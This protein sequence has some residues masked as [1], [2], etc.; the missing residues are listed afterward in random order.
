MTA[1]EQNARSPDRRRSRA[2]RTIYAA[3]IVSALTLLVVFANAHLVYVAITSQPDCVAHVKSGQSS[4]G[5]FNA[6]G[7]AC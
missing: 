4:P 2:R 7:S 5:Q 1:F 3:V 6:A